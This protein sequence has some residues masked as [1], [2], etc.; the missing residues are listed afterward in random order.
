MWTNNYKLL[1]MLWPFLMITLGLEE[2]PT[3][4]E[5]DSRTL[6]FLKDAS[7]APTGFTSSFAEQR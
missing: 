1:V 3:H 2:P 7:V 5:R 4:I 6:S